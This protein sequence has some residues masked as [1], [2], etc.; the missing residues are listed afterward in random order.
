M[1]LKDY[2]KK[3]LHTKDEKKS[4]TENDL[5]DIQN[6]YKELIDEFMKRYG[7]MDEKQMI[8]EMFGLIKTKKEQGTFDLSQIKEI[9]IKVSPFLSKDQQD[10]MFD[11]LKKLG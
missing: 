6:N 5:N 1:N 4:P 10:Y 2:S 9:A 8:D 7:K 11:L 3:D